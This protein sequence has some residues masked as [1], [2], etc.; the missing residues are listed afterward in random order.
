MGLSRPFTYLLP[1]LLAATLASCST[2]PTV[3]D[4]P[5]VIAESS[6]ATIPENPDLLKFCMPLVENI[7]RRG[8]RIGIPVY[9]HSARWGDVLRV[10]ITEQDDDIAT[11]V[12]CIKNFVS[13]GVTP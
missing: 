7:S 5:T 1:M 13:V 6:E 4:A 3:V 10:Q 8:G 2:P 9:T 11:R 12:A